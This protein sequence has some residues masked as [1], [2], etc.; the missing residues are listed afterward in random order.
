MAE[1]ISL[2]AQGE[3]YED[4]IGKAMAQLLG[5]CGKTDAKIFRGEPDMDAEPFRDW[6]L[7]STDTTVSS[8]GNTVLLEATFFLYGSD[9]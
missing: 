3:S 8:G 9:E 6:V 2:N 1:F 7:D 5:I 4:A